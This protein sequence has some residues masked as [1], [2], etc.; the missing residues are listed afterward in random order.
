VPATTH[1]DEP[2]HDHCL[3]SVWHL[4]LRC[5]FFLFPFDAAIPSSLLICWLSHSTR[6]VCGGRLLPHEEHF[7][8]AYALHRV[9]LIM[10][11]TVVLLFFEA[12]LI[13]GAHPPALTK[14]MRGLSDE[15]LC[16]WSVVAGT[17]TE[18]AWLDVVNSGRA[19]D[20]IG[21]IPRL[22]MSCSTP[23]S[24]HEAV[25]DKAVNHN[26]ACPASSTVD[27]HVSWLSEVQWA[28][29]Q[30]SELCSELEVLKSEEELFSFTTGWMY[31]DD[32]ASGSGRTLVTPAATMALAA[33]VRDINVAIRA[34]RETRMT[35]EM[36]ETTLGRAVPCGG[37]GVRV[38]PGLLVIPLAVVLLGPAV[39]SIV[40][41]CG[42]PRLLDAL[43]EERGQ[44][45]V[46]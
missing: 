39:A 13:L 16:S 4:S 15:E 3:T 11:V 24:C 23:T 33:R 1:S 7:S 32:G 14:T 40:A 35:Q 38:P 31:A 44:G 29:A 42:M 10:A 5:P 22:W 17:A 2:A 20:A 26:P 9:A 43:A 34:A 25:R 12:A 45:H 18:Q 37:A 27:M 46:A 41:A 36:M 19:S 6:N 21:T 30:N 28:F 8:T